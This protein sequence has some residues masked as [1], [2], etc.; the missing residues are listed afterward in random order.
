MAPLYKPGTD[1]VLRSLALLALGTPAVVLAGLMLGQRSPLVTG[2][3]EAVPQP[4]QFDHRH[5]TAD[6]GIDCRYCHTTVM[7]SAH[8]GIPPIEL[9]MG[10]HAQVWNESPL[11]EP[12][13]KASFDDVPIAWRSV[14]RLPDFVY[15]NHAIHV[16]K[17][18]GCVTCHGRVDEMALVYQVVPLNMGWCLDCHRN[19]SPHLRPLEHVTDVAWKPKEEPE[20]LGRRLAQELDVHPSVECYT[21]HR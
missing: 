16:N 5:H 10:C 9:C 15:F 2:Q 1:T 20:A 3:Y 12:L 17:G 11:L 8:A 18:V 7:V 21:C 14:H 6:E 4:L 13:R 19:P